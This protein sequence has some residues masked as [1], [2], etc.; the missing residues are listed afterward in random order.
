MLLGADNNKLCVVG[1]CR[2]ELNNKGRTALAEVVIIKGATKNLLGA[3]EIR[4]LNLLA[5]V[6]SLAKPSSAFDPCE[7][8]PGVFEGLMCLGLT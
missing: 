2:V 1:E 5:V 4:K 7:V 8:Y 3:S 6:Q